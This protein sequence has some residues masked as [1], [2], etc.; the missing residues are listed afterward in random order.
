MTDKLRLVHSIELQAVQKIR[1]F[2]VIQTG[3]CG[4]AALGCVVGFGHSK[5]SFYK[6]FFGNRRNASVLPEQ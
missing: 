6:K 5:N 2:L 3:F 1:I 4:V